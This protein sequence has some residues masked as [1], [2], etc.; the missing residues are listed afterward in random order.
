MDFRHDARP[1]QVGTRLTPEPVDPGARITDLEREKLQ[2][3]K[4][5]TSHAV[6]DQAIGVVIAV[7][8][9]HPRQ[10]FDVLKNVSQ[11]TNRKLRAVAGL[12]IDWVSGEPLPDD[13]R[14]SLDDALA[15]ARAESG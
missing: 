13:V 12:V 1:E 6:V 14:R 7:G 8:G 2:L 3:Q 11:H 5:I 9:L 4:T 10:G 15:K